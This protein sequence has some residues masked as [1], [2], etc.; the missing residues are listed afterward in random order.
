MNLYDIFY[1][2]LC[3]IYD[4][5]VY[6]CFILVNVIFVLNM[7]FSYIYNYMFLKLWDIF[8]DLCYICC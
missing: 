3:F 8:Y 1:F 6:I 4:I 2:F 5:Y 7:L